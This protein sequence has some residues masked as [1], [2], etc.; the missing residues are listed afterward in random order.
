MFQKT[1]MS[2]LDDFI[3]H[4]KFSNF[5]PNNVIIKG[6]SNLSIFDI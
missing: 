2:P 5:D 3:E 4:H 6:E 1:I